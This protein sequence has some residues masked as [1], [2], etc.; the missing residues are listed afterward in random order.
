MEET[1]KPVH[2]V[3]LLVALAALIALVW[4]VSS[5]AADGSPSTGAAQSQAQP[6]QYGGAAPSAQ[7]DQGQGGQD[8]PEHDGSGGSGG[9][10]S[11]SPSQPAAPS[12]TPD[13]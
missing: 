3:L 12:A 9:G 10:Q 4:A 8:C 6:V 1:R 13:V 11:E 2:R 7:S 5:W